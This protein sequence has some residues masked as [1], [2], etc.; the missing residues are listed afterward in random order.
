MACADQGAGGAWRFRADTTGL[1]SLQKL[2]HPF[3]AFRSDRDEP[4]PA[5]RRG[6]PRRLRLM[7]RNTW[8]LT[9]GAVL[10]VAG[11]AAV[12]FY[13]ASRPTLLTIAVP[14]GD[15]DDMRMMQAIGQQFARER[16]PIRL[17]AVTTDGPLQSASE[18]DAG[19]V[20]LAIVRADIGLPREGLAVAVLRRNLVAIM[21]PAPGSIATGP[22]SAASERRHG[23][24]KGKPITAVDHLTGKR[25]GVVGRGGFNADVLGVILR[26]HEVP[27]DKV[28]V[29]PLDP[30]NVA[31]ALRKTPVDAIVTVGPV[32]SRFIAD[33]LAAASNGDKRPTFVPVPSSEAIAGRNPA[34]ESTEIA[35]GAFGGAKPL[36]ADSVETI[37]FSHYIVA[38]RGVSD[39]K[40]A[41]FT[42]LLFSVRQ[43]LAKEV[44]A[45]AK[46]EKPDTDKDAVVQ[47]HPGAAAYLDDE[48]QTFL[49][50]YSDLLYWGVMLM[51]FAGSAAAWL[52]SY[53]RA[54]DRVRRMRV[55]EQLLGIVR[56]ARDATTLAEIDRLRQE[57][58]AI[59]VRTLHQVE[60]DDFEE[61][62]LMAFS[63]ALDQ[64]QL[65]INDRRAS[66][67]GAGGEAP[68]GPTEATEPPPA[69]ADVT[70]LR[71]AIKAA[72]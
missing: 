37:G 42:R 25:V 56:A 61:S 49:D 26:Q 34:Y 30:D 43:A 23:K 5:S 50:R 1:L 36:P 12:G 28:T 24:G 38:R 70:P 47:A 71:L 46:I 39:T 15:G 57:V 58:D 10:L 48:Q 29:V 22:A 27:A 14:Y 60:R 31:A 53:A 55:I 16:A 33:A 2:R 7:V 65:A 9:L 18:L 52:M 54:D 69:E 40:V 68:S 67:L 35:E 64:A 8:L 66:L 6:W 3:R 13:I 41:D 63:L 32:T 62:S 19:R 51:S 11:L 17:R 59:L 21:V 4:A 20:D 44:P 72:E 45:I